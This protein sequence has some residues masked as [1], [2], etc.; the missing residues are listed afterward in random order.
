MY[1]EEKYLLMALL[2]HRKINV[3]DFY[4]DTCF[5]T[6]Q[7]VRAILKYQRKGYLV[8]FG[9]VILRTPIGALK[10]RSLLHKEIKENN[11]Y[12]AKVPDE[13]LKERMPINAPID[14]IRI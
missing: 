3:Y 6:G 4:V 14:N 5:S 13:Y 2:S 12:W 11:R 7:I 1:T 10:M 8:M 9:K